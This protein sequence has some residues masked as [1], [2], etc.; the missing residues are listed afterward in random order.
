MTRLH[1]VRTPSLSRACL[2]GLLLVSAA[3]AAD[4]IVVGGRTYER[5]GATLWRLDGGQRFLVQ[6][7]VVSVRLAAGE[8]SFDALVASLGAAAGPL[9]DLS[10]RRSN[11]LGVLDLDLA[12]HD[13]L[14]VTARLLATGRV[15]FAEP[16]TLGRYDG[17]PNDPGFPNQWNLKNTGQSGGTPGADVNAVAAWDL[18]GGD[19]SVVVAVIDS[20]TEYFHPDLAPN[21]W[22]NAGEVAGNGQDDDGNGF[23]DDVDGWDFANGNNDPSS[24]YFHGTAVAGVIVARGDDGL[25]IAGLAGGGDSGSACRVMPLGIGEFGPVASVIDDAIVYAIDNGARVITLSLSVPQSSAIDLAL[26]QAYAAGLFIDCA[27]GNNGASVGYPATHVDVMAVAS[28]NRFDAVSSFSNPGPQVEVTA[29]GE[30]VYMTNLGGGYTTSSG[31]SFSAP[32]VGALAA[33]VLSLNPL[34]T[35]V[36]VR[37]IL[38]ASA[39]DIGAPGFDN[40]SGFGRI[41]ALAALQLADGGTIGS[42][43][44]YG[45]GTAGTQGKTPLMIAKG[46]APQ[47][48]NAAFAVKVDDA[49]GSSIAHLVLG[50]DQAAYAF[51]GGTLLVEVALPYVTLDVMTSFTLGS[52]LG[53]ATVPL[54]I[55]ADALLVGIELDLQWLVSDPKAP[56]GLSMSQGLAVVIGG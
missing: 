50:L 23:V 29:P 25:G 33:L 19:P 34:L 21:M 42:T 11:R 39:H 35:N 52:P 53:A 48:G 15:E 22:K 3:S 17:T 31:T 24:G 14:D 4:P 55:P 20:G 2:F 18:T 27:S 38:K 10:V 46:G 13:P 7:D 28:S 56:V 12:G 8:K 16:D 5:D 32:H 51:K 44:L 1:R 49:R 43:A 26:S 41:D 45:T 30:D 54:A 6:P 37:E 40:A 36:E 47:I 9:A